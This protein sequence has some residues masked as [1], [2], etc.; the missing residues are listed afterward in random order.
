MR[1]FIFFIFVILQLLSIVEAVQIDRYTVI[2]NIET[3]EQKDEL[4]VIVN[5]KFPTNITKISDALEHLLL[6]SSYKLD[7]SHEADR[8]TEFD[9][10]MVHRHI[11]PMTL[12]RA[13]KVLIG[14]DVW[15]L[16][17]DK[18]NRQIKIV[19]KDRTAFNDKTVN[20]QVN[21]PI[22]FIDQIVKINIK[23]D[24]LAIVLKR[25]LPN[26]WNVQI[27][28]DLLPLK[29]DVISENETRRVVLQNIFNQINAQ[30]TYLPKMRLLVVKKIKHTETLDKVITNANEK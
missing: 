19:A 17:I 29:V 10:P 23:Q 26:S 14:I 8:L 20:F 25:I 6:R 30:G 13:I 4:L 12:K 2:N 18:L 1:F 27:D 16:E 28:T 22:E 5:I 11:G 15:S 24:D 3:K 7:L 21:A 9:L